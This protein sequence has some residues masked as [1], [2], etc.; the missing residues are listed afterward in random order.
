MPITAMAFAAAV[1][2]EGFTAAN[3]AVKAVAVHPIPVTPDIS[4]SPFRIRIDPAALDN[5]SSRPLTDTTPPKFADR[6]LRCF[7]SLFG[8]MHAFDAF[9]ALFC[10]D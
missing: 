8:R 2:Y 9:G 3:A 5:Q 10:K 7:K 4:G 1:K 6:S